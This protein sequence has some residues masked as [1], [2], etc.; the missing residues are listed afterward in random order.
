MHPDTAA[1][2]GVA[3]GDWVRIESPHGWVKLVAE[4][5][6]TIPPGVLM[7]RRGWWQACAE[8][9][10]PGYGC[11]DGGSECAVL[12]ASDPARSDAFHSAMAKQTL[13]RMGVLGKGGDVGAERVATKTAAG[14]VGAPTAASAGEG[15][16]TVEGHASAADAGAPAG[17]G[18][19]TAETA[20]PTGV[21][22]A[23]RE[24]RRGYSFD[25]SRC[26][27]CGA[28]VVACKQWNGI[29]AGSPARCRLEEGALAVG[30]SASG[31]L[32]VPRFSASVCLRCRPA[33]CVETCPTQ[34]LSLDA[35]CEEAGKKVVA[36]CATHA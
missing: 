20:A 8:L 31:A 13:V 10:L 7:A 21:G 35:A 24:L 3:D 5:A 12:Y 22:A 34:A 11:L 15:A 1:A 29:P 33:H 28:C 36:P 2:H 23:V 6:P 4:T 9:G 18:T 19:A 14:A 17:V 25:A 16:A 27:G 30:A 32:A 26:I